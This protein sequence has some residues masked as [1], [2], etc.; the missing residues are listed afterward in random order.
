MVTVEKSGGNVTSDKQQVAYLLSGSS[1]GGGEPEVRAPKTRRVA[2][3]ALQEESVNASIHRRQ[4]VRVAARQAAFNRIPK[5]THEQNKKV[6]KQREVQDEEHFKQLLADIEQGCKV[7]VPRAQRYVDTADTARRK[8]QEVL[9]TEWEETV[10][11][12]IQNRIMAEVAKRSSSDVGHRLQLQH[13]QYLDAVNRTRGI[14]RDTIIPAEYDPLQ[15]HQST[16]RVAVGDIEDPVKRDILK[17]AKEKQLVLG[18]SYMG[19]GGGK[20]T[21]PPQMWDKTSCTP[22]TRCINASGEYAP[23]ILSPDVIAKRASHVK[24]DMVDMAIGK[25]AVLAEYPMGK[26]MVPGPEA[27]SGRRDLS[28]LMQPCGDP[29]AEHKALDDAWLHSTWTEGR[30]K[31]DGPEVKQGRRDL[32]ECLQQS[33]D[34]HDK[35]ALGD[36]WLSAKGRRQVPGPEERRGRKDLYDVL[37]HKERG[38]IQKSRTL[39]DHYLETMWFTGLGRQAGPMIPGGR[40]DLFAILEQQPARPPGTM[41]A[42]WAD[43]A[44]L[45]IRGRPTQP[46]KGSGQAVRAALLGEGQRDPRWRP[47]SRP[48][49][50]SNISCLESLN[51]IHPSHEPRSTSARQGRSNQSHLLNELTLHPA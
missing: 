8:K 48:P 46:E 20:L 38:I 44:W 11:Q 41:P 26:R 14:F 34:V 7:I 42:D 45:T 33:K 40:K 25:E 27:R 23:R 31:V 10:F 28:G 24:L 4:L 5:K 21:L 32:T 1:P 18:S 16:I 9:H 6:H 47:A 12:K 51:T 39:G 22:A 2:A 15:P 43:D 49:A 13:Q 19:G 3:P 36:S 50:Q 37:E 17:D 29:Y 30:K 35:R